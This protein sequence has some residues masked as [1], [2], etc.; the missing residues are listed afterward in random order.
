MTPLRLTPDREGLEL[1]RRGDKALMRAGAACVCASVCIGASTIFS[2]QA[3]GIDPHEVIKPALVY[4]EA[5]APKSDHSKLVDSAATGVVISADGLVLTSYHLLTGLG[6]YDKSQL[7]IVAQLPGQ[8]TLKARQENYREDL[9]L[10]LLRLL[11]RTS[12]PHASLSKFTLTSGENANIYI[13]G[14]TRHPDNIE[15]YHTDGK[16]LDEGTDTL[17]QATDIPFAEEQIGSPVYDKEGLLRG[18]VNLLDTDRNTYFTPLEYADDLLSVVQI[19]TGR[20]A[21]HIL[22]GDLELKPDMPSY[23]TR[24]KEIEKA[25]SALRYQFNWQQPVL[26]Q[27]GKRLLLRYEKLLSGEPLVSWI[28]VQ[29][30]PQGIQVPTPSVGST[31]DCTVKI[32]TTESECTA[33]VDSSGQGATFDLSAYYDMVA[34]LHQTYPEA[35]FEVR[36]DPNPLPDGTKLEPEFFTIAF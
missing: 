28:I 15:Y 22:F 24:V 33:S 14:Y 34:G 20:Q 3:A 9:S 1:S 29:V 32:G 10:L 17:L 18:I 5:T 19:S 11:P 13:S 26:D 35:R 4:L 25:I 8:K 7:N 21:F 16:L 12:Y 30:V 23:D 36:I 6:V 27:K 2:A 31:P